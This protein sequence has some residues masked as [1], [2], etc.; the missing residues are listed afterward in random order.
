MKMKR[1]P[2]ALL[3]LSLLVA[4]M[5]MPVHSA[6]S[7]SYDVYARTDKSSYVPGDSGTLYITV[8]NSGTGT[9]TVH[10]ISIN[11]P[12]KAFVIDH[13][14]GNITTNNINQPVGTPGGT[15]NSQYSFT[16]PTDGRAYYG[17]VAGLSP[18][19]VTIGTDITTGNQQ[20]FYT[21]TTPISIA[22]STYQPLDLTTSVLPIVSIILIAAAVAMLAF[23]Y[24]GIRKL[25]KK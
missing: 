9:F 25:S 24:M 7:Y 10:N 13:W 14:D 8:K 23:V 12:W 19:S 17:N 11:Y 4:V 15:W 16:V 5:L 6:A 2:V 3:A 1:A 21:S 22:V 20:G 18:I